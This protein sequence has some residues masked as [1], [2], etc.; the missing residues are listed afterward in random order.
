MNNIER[1]WLKTV[2]ANCLLN[3]N[4]TIFLFYDKCYSP[5][6]L[7]NSVCNRLGHH[8]GTICPVP[9]MF[10]HTKQLDNKEFIDVNVVEM[11]NVD[12]KAKKWHNVT[13]GH[14]NMIIV[15]SSITIV[16]STSSLPL[17]SCTLPEL[18]WPSINKRCVTVFID[19]CFIERPNSINSPNLNGVPLIPIANFLQRISTRMMHI[20]RWLCSKD[21]KNL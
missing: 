12:A 13:Y 5:P 16:Q 8:I 20:G 14:A 17:I 15:L 2:N 7:C 9:I 19:H 1:L 10:G 18:I 3:V 4:G 11:I 21:N 6:T